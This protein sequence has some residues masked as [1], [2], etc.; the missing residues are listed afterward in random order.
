[1]KTREILQF[2]L[3]NY[4]SPE[5]CGIVNV[6]EDDDFGQYFPDL[7]DSCRAY[8]GGDYFY[9]FAEDASYET[10]REKLLDFGTKE[11]PDVELPTSD[12]FFCLVKIED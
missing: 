6:E 10:D 4:V 9:F 8:E 7:T 3:T 11:F 12:G 2:V 5:S 1:M